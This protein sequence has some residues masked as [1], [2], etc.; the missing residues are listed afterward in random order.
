LLDRGAGGRHS[1]GI[2]RAGAEEERT[3]AGNITYAKCLRASSIWAWVG[4]AVEPTVSRV[5]VP[6]NAAMRALAE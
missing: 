3:E 1:G 6:D 4:L 2:S 5:G